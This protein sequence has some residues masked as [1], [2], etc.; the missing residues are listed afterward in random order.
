MSNHGHGPQ[1]VHSRLYRKYGYA[2][3]HLCAWCLGPALDWAFLH[4]NGEALSSDRLED[5]APMCRG[6]HLRWDHIN[7]QRQA[8]PDFGGELGGNAFAE[9]RA[10]DPEFSAEMG[11]IQSRAASLGGVAAWKK[12][13]DEKTEALRRGRLRQYRCEDCGYI[14]NAG[15]VAR[16]Q[17][18][19]NHA[20]RSDV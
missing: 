9:K 1:A 5:Y 6:C 15:T 7:G 16:H 19:E 10:T 4:T 3:E 18:R 17:K 8:P 2:R 20:G 13:R 12:H 14:N 11:I